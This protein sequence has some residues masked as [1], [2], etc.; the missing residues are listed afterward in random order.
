MG[1]YIS[2]LSPR[3]SNLIEMDRKIFVIGFNKTATVSM[4]TVFLNNRLRSQHDGGKPWDVD[5]YDVFSDGDSIRKFREFDKNFEDAIF[6]LNTRS[7]RKWLESRYKHGFATLYFEGRRPEQFG[8]YNWAWPPSV[9]KTMAWIEHRQN[10]FSS[11]LS[12][13]EDRPD[14]LIIVN[15][16]EPNWIGFLCKSLGL[17]NTD[18][19]QK[20]SSPLDH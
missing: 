5:N 17:E 15:I 12:H 7:L 8:K 19:E 13:F 10:H 18:E 6:V 3:K 16:E 20:K 14:R 9:E 2:Q 4:H 11:V 1:Y